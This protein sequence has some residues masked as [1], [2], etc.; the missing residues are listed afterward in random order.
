MNKVYILQAIFFVAVAA[1]I[2]H[3]IKKGAPPL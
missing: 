3:C 2:Q 1:Y